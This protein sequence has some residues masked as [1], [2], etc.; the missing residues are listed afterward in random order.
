M[1][2]ARWKANNRGKLKIVAT[3]EKK[4]IRELLLKLNEDKIQALEKTGLL[5]K[6]KG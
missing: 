4:T 1:K 6:G 2:P 3:A 5:P